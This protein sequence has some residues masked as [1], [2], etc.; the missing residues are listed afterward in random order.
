MYEYD[1]VEIRLKT[2]WKG[3]QPQEDYR[4]VIARRARDGW[5]LVQIFAPPVAGYGAAVSYELVFE[6]EARY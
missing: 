1:F 2:G 4:E 3:R 5:R 6:R